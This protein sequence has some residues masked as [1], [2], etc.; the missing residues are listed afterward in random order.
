MLFEYP[1]LCILSARGILLGKILA[2][3]SPHNSAEHLSQFH[4]SGPEDWDVC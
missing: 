1:F 3:T 2:E 4:R